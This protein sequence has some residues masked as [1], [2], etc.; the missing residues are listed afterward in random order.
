MWSWCKNAYFCKS[1]SLTQQFSNQ[2]PY[3][4][5]LSLFFFTSYSSFPWV[6][7]IS[8]DSLLVISSSC[9]WLSASH[10]L[11]SYLQTYL[12]P[13]GNV[14][15]FMSQWQHPH[16]FTQQLL[17]AY[18]VPGHVLSQGD[19]IKLTIFWR[20]EVL[21][22]EQHTYIKFQSVIQGIKGRQK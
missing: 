10:S 20:R 19:K 9:R 12:H 15:I 14:P 18:H 2:M 21:I 7:L 1:E 11:F 22:Q 16:L 3:S 4:V 13:T 6:F 5:F 17:T 8:L